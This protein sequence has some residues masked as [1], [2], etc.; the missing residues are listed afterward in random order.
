[1]RPAAHAQATIELLDLLSADGYPADRTMAQYF[2]Q[3][4]YIGSKDKKAVSGQ[5]YAVLRNRLS[6][7][8]L[9]TEV[10]LQPSSRL[11]VAAYLRTLGQAT[12]EVFDDQRYHPARFGTTQIEAL[13]SIDVDVLQSAPMHVQLNVPAWIEPALMDALGADY[14]AE[15]QA[16]NQRATTDIRVNSLRADREQVSAALTAAGMDHDLCE[17]APQG[18]RFRQRVALFNLPAFKQGHFEVQ[19]EGSQLLALA[20]GASAGQKVVDFCAGAGGKTLAMAAMMQNRGSV[21]ACD[22]HSGRLQQLQ[23][24]CRRAGVH[25]VRIV[26]LSSERDKWVKQHTGYADLVL[27][28]APCSG[29]GTWR[30]NPDARWNLTAQGLDELV[31][32]QQ[33]ILTSAARLVRPG[34]RLLYATCSLLKEE[35]EQQVDRFL[36]QNTEFQHAAPCDHAAFIEHQDRFRISESSISTSPALTGTDGFYLCALQR[37]AHQGL[38]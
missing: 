28:D 16:M 9:L 24:R 23:K 19:D 25:N 34:G 29:T 32:L 13:R 20:S 35:N 37:G 1:M 10:G 15:M 31:E 21:Y 30:R 2:K 5:F 8:Y 14:P 7:Q 3:R 6:L 12:E 38:I 26:Q 17:L 33:S 27:I 18:I 4:R 36:A 11:L 22:V